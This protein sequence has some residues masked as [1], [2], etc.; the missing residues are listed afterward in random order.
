MLYAKHT[1]TYVASPALYG[2]RGD[3]VRKFLSVSVR[4]Q[5]QSQ[6][7]QT[8]SHRTV[9]INTVRFIE[10]LI[11]KRLTQIPGIP[12]IQFRI[13]II[14]E[15]PCKRGQLQ[16]LVIKDGGGENRLGRLA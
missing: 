6:S 1:G 5:T 2:A 11:I 14:T 9:V 10:I 15:Q 16:K 7:K 8:G 4:D 3:V 13:L 12:F